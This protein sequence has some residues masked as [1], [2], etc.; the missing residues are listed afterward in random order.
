M[1]GGRYE[2]VAHKR[3]RT[4]EARGKT[5][6]GDDVRYQ[7]GKVPEAQLLRLSTSCHSVRPFP[8]TPSVGYVGSCPGLLLCAPI[9]GN[10]IAPER[11]SLSTRFFCKRASRTPANPFPL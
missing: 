5:V 1:R 6:R 7:E 8:P 3:R 2:H 11:P 10:K 9:F 4:L